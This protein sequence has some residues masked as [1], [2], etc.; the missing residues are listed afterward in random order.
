MFRYTAPWQVLCQSLDHNGRRL[1]SGDI[2]A[3]QSFH[4]SSPLRRL[5]S[6][7]LP[8]AGSAAPPADMDSIP[9]R[10]VLKPLSPVLQPSD[11]R[12][13]T[14]PTRTL[15][16]DLDSPV[17]S[18]DN[19][20]FTRTVVVSSQGVQ[21]GDVGVLARQVEV[22]RDRGSSSSSSDDWHPS[23]PSSSSGSQSGFYSFVEDPT[24]PE[25][26]LNEA[27]MISPR[28]Q[29]QLTILKE[30]KGFKLQTYSSNRKPENL[31]SDGNDLRYKVD[32]ANGLVVVQEAEE[33]KL[34]QQIIRG[35]A[36]KMSPA[37]KD[38]SVDLDRS[39][40][41][42]VE[43]FSLNYSPV[44]SR[45]EPPPVEP[46]TIDNEQIN[47]SAARQQFLKIEQ[48]R[49]AALLNPLKSSKTQLNRS[50]QLDP[51]VS[52]SQQVL[53]S[54]SVQVTED[55]PRF[56]LIEEEIFPQRRVMVSRTEDSLSRQ[57]SVFDD[58]DSGLEE[59]S[60][61]VG[62]GYTS[63]EG[64][65]DEKSTRGD[66]TPIEREIRLVQEREE[67]LRRSRG[68][69]LSDGR[70]EMVQIRT[71]RLS[72][73][74]SPVKAREKNRVSFVVQRE[75]QKDS[76][77]KEEPEQGGFPGR[78]SLSS[79]QEL[80]Y[81]KKVFDQEDEVE[82]RKL[83]P[84]SEEFPSPCCPHR[85]PEG[86]EAYIS[87]MSSSQLFSL[88]DSVVQDSRRF[89]RERTT[90]TTSSSSHSSSSHSSPLI[91]RH[92][93]T[94][95]TPQSWRES[96]ESTGLRSRGLKAPDFI[97]KEI[98][99]AL[100][101]EQELKELRESREEPDQQI[102]FQSPVVEQ[103]AKITVTHSYPPLKTEKS[104][105][106]SSLSPRPFT[107]L[108]SITAQPWT[109][110]PPPS[111]TLSTSEVRQT[112]P[113]VRGLTETLLQD[114]EERR[115]QLRLEESAVVESTRV[116]RHKNQRA[117]LWEAGMFANQEDQ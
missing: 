35:Q 78:Y 112:P 53:V 101:R 29:T 90:S 111:S 12:T 98:E 80:G 25:A 73:L 5:P 59:Q 2:S 47:F 107:R 94:P 83:R 8:P 113:P 87:Q 72:S 26:E 74:Q 31:F 28:R 92:D 76:R 16:P 32:P 21:S 34:R 60:L 61:E 40:D 82:G 15:I 13:I 93:K 84:K 30:E 102:R 41:R 108:P 6:E 7:T 89:Y 64:L 24:S 18:P 117:L 48:D 43:G 4:T 33:K 54:E 106:L 63:D 67:N 109:Y 52:S 46:G 27:W 68:M 14:S 66:E 71:K 96:L 65:F 39:T 36:P 75:I 110:T 105:P 103:A 99:E 115:V 3:S 97:E 77:K 11:L 45:P 20:S 49:M 85:H 116:I 42:L 56:R 104:V 88:K 55:T 79:P 37:Y 70:M 86:T 10:W 58:L 22:S 114:F 95:T 9:R 19:I 57:S 38:S 62:G 100:R 44:R 51:E 23:S 91:Q 50:L 81:T 69:K 1:S 17:F